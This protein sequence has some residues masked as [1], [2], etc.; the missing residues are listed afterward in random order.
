MAI[1]GYKRALM[2]IWAFVV[3]FLI[4]CVPCLSDDSS[5][6]FHYV[7]DGDIA[8]AVHLPVYEWYP[9]QKPDGLVLAIHG[10]TLHGLRYE[11]LAKT[12]AVDNPMGCYYVVAPDM[13]GF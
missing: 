9:K 3:S 13:R 11:V 8:K 7:K 12:L 1:S 6:R 10:L 2:G 4:L 5:D